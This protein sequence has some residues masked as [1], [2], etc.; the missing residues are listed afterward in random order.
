MGESGKAAVC[1]ALVVV[2]GLAMAGG[3]SPPAEMIQI[4][5]Y[6]FDE[7]AAKEGRIVPLAGATVIW[8]G[9]GVSGRA[10]LDA[11]GHYFL[12]APHG[13]PLS[14]TVVKPDGTVKRGTYTP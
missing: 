11:Y 9:R 4:H 6:L 2:A 12:L 8:E 5:G 3:S 7:A 14:L 10:V 1:A 13:F